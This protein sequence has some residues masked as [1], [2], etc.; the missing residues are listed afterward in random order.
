M[1]VGGV[2]VVEM[3]MQVDVS[4]LE[5]KLRKVHRVITICDVMIMT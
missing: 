2:H 5:Q 1:H 4:E 3:W